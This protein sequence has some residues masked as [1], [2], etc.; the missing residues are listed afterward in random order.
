ML[1][2][3]NLLVVISLLLLVLIIAGCGNI[4]KPTKGIIH[5]KVLAPPSE[6]GLTRDISGWVPV[7]NAAVTIKDDKGVIH[8]ANTDSEGNF[9]FENLTV[10]SN[11]IVTATVK[12]NGKTIILKGLIDKAVAKDE[13]YDVGILTAYST[14][15]ALLVERHGTDGKV[16]DLDKIKGADSFGDLI[17]EISGVLENHGNVIGD[18]GV[19]DLIDKIMNELFPGGEGGTPAKAVTA[20]TVK[21]QPTKLSYFAG[22]ALDLTGLV[23]TLTYNDSSTEDVALA[24]FSSKGI[25]AVPA[26]GTTL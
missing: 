10:K 2:K 12:I 9:S 8:T 23:V 5:G 4:P 18:K 20:I 11:T 26:N 22:D 16:I 15:L 13:N 3:K 25:T 17:G 24:N 7:E 19:K 1:R 14:G 6:K 21:T